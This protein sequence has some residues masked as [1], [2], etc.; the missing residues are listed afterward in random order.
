[1][2]HSFRVGDYHEV[3]AM[4]WQNQV[5]S[6]IYW[7]AKAD[8]AR[9]LRCVLESYK[10]DSRWFALEEGYWYQREDGKLK[11][12]CSAAPV[13]GIADVEFLSV[14]SELKTASGL[15]KLA[16]MEDPSWA[17]GDVIAELQRR[18]IAGL[19]SALLDFARRS[20]R[21]GVS[22]DGR[23]LLIVRDHYADDVEDGFIELNRP[24][25]PDR[26]YSTQVINFFSW[27]EDGTSWG[28][29]ALPRDANVEL[30]EIHG[31]TCRLKIRRMT[32]GRLLSFADTIDAIRSLS[33]LSFETPLQDER[34]WKGLES[35]DVKRDAEGNLS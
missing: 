8:P 9:D 24:P 7:S 33:V 16:E 27:G 23:K 22:E 13:I 34:L 31:D 11:V 19:D 5:R 18:F 10:G 1:M 32:T 30:I 17:A 15:A 35:A 28:K 14:K 25:A 20:D 12:W 21:I 4:V 2:V 29:A 3:V 26:G 6:I